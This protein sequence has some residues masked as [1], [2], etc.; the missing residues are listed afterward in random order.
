LKEKPEYKEIKQSQKG[1][2]EK[3]KQHDKDIQELKEGQK[4][5][6][7]KQNEMKKMLIRLD[8][9]YGDLLGWQ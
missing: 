1:I 8:G 9:R 2:E 4:R 7:E 5:I 6:E 3:L